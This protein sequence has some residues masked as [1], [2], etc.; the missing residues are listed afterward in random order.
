MEIFHNAINSLSKSP[1]VASGENKGFSL[2]RSNDYLSQN[3]D[4]VLSINTSLLFSYL[5]TSQV[6]L[7]HNRYVLLLSDDK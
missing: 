5:V 7:G 3:P 6:Y 1:V 2:K 4:P